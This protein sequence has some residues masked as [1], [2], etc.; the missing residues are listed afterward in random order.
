[1]PDQS[2]L[3]PAGD[4][5]A[6]AAA[7]LAALRAGRPDEAEG[8][9]VKAL[10]QQPDDIEA[11]L[12]LA[13]LYLRRRAFGHSEPLLAS[14]LARQ[15]GRPEA[16]SARVNALIGLNHFEEAERL[17]GAGGVDEEVRRAAELRVRQYWAE[18]LLARRNFAAAERQ[19]RRV[20]EIT[21]TDPEAH[22]D[23][24]RLCLAANRTPE[25]LEVLETALRLEPG[26]VPSL[27]NQGTAYRNQGRLA[28]AEASYHRALAADPVNVHAVRNLGVLL[29]QQGR[30]AEADALDEQASVGGADVGRGHLSRADALAA[31]GRNQEALAAI[32]LA[33]A[34]GAD[35]FDLL[36]RLG[37][38]LEAEG[39]YAEAIARL[40]EAAALCPDR[41]E[42]PFRRGFVRLVTGDFGRGW[43]DYEAR[44]RTGEHLAENDPLPPQVR[45]RLLHAPT[46]EQMAGRK[47]VAIAEQG[48]GDQIMFASILPDLA[49]DAARVQC[50]CS[51]RLVS[52]FSSSFPQVEVR[53]GGSIGDADVVVAMG[54]LGHAYRRSRED[55]SPA[56]FLKP[57]EDVRARWAARLGP[58]RRLRVGLSWRGG[59]PRTRMHQRSMSLD[60]L[61]PLLE[62][63]ECEFVSL[64]Y[65]DVAGEIATANARLASPILAFPP[66]EIH[67]FADLAGLALNLDLVV[68][69]QTAL[70]HLAGGLGVPT[71]AMIRRVPEW[72]YGADGDTLPWYGSVRMIRQAAEG[73]WDAIIA[74]VVERLR[75]WP[76]P[77]GA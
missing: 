14:V 53:S 27:I 12:N 21:P 3:D 70:V 58:R 7:A 65:G 33:A 67:D 18:N 34:H 29:R 8:L 71:L 56:A 66:A 49:R 54:S 2:P 31:A 45:A 48:L 51:D 74:A 42:A 1:M 35:R 61:A 60:L 32:D 15:P 11:A 69:V 55:F 30:A 52:L 20:L 23:L 47:V 44:L 76:A 19:L 4:G 10:H 77:A 37:G 68:S 75:A 39:R 16:W 59:T 25:A 57:P 46:R 63:P 64:Q 41:P 6:L 28:E 36:C 40:D 73:E 13:L 62:L 38:V 24:A 43:S 9:Y 50:M 72:R 22:N 5:A 17:V 26:H